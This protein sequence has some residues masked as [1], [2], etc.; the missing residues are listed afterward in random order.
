MQV[1]F[2]QEGTIEMRVLLPGNLPWFFSS[3]WITIYKGVFTI[4][5]GLFSPAG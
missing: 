3:A 2:E 4:I 1:P 5:F